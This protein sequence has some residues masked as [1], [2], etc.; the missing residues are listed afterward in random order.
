[1][2]R[3]TR[4]SMT[5]SNMRLVSFGGEAG[6]VL[7][8]VAVCC[9]VLQ[10]VAMCCNVFKCVAVCCHFGRE[11]EEFSRLHQN[12]RNESCHTYE[13]IQTYIHMHTYTHTYKHVIICMQHWWRRR[14]KYW[15]K[16]KSVDTEFFICVIKR[17]H[18]IHAFSYIYS[19]G[20]DA[21]RNARSN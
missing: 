18:V 11:K 2:T 14:E 8:C 9:N 6:S 1:M 21:G 17:V 19:F 3:V 16:L 12:C 20:G 10:C 5:L 15:I 13:Y 7:Q 4:L